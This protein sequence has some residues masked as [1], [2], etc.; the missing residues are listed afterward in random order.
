MVC[1]N[2]TSTNNTSANNNTSI[3]IGSGGNATYQITNATIGNGTTEITISTTGKGATEITINTPGNGTAQDNATATNTTGNGTAGQ[4]CKKVC[5][6]IE[7]KF[8]L[9]SNWKQIPLANVTAELK[10]EGINYEYVF[11]GLWLW[12]NHKPTF[13]IILAIFSMY[14]IVQILFCRMRQRDR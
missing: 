12:E 1:T 4:T 5:T 14:V 6:P 9:K 2:N 11:Y 7:T 10:K 13:I 8:N 3:K